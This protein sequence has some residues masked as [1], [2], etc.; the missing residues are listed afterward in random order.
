VAD[1][2]LSGFKPIKKL[3][4]KQQNIFGKISVYNKW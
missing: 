2:K 4:K 3:T 1:E